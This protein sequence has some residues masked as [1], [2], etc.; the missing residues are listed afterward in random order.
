MAATCHEDGDTDGN[1]SGDDDGDDLVSP[2][3]A[4]ERTDDRGEEARGSS[5]VVLARATIDRF[6]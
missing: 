1:N 2:R 6:A 4:L 5:V 3:D